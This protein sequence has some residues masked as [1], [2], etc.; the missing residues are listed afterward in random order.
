MTPHDR[1]T[2]RD[3]LT[4]LQ[5]AALTALGEAANQT[6][7]GIAAVVWSLK[8]RTAIKG[9]RLAY[10]AFHTAAYSCWLD[11]PASHNDDALVALAALMVAG[12]MAPEDPTLDACLLIA[13]HV[14]SG[15]Y[16]VDPT[17]GATHY[18][19]PAIVHPLP[20]WTQPPAEQTVTIGAHV[21]YRKVAF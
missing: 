15:R 12:K 2:Y 20:T 6:V 5:A 1:L 11:D 3:A 14:L 10:Q 21:F 16:L 7:R 19:N 4:D 18:Y 13:D 8:N 9:G 17:H